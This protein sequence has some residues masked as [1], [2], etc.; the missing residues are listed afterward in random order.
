MLACS[1]HLLVL[2]CLWLQKYSAEPHFYGVF[3]MISQSPH[4]VTST[5]R[6]PAESRASL[7]GR[8]AVPP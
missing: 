1:C 2:C 4:I 8:D 5:T 3:A 6:S 7:A